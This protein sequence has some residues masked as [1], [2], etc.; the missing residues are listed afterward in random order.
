MDATWHRNVVLEGSVD[1]MYWG[2]MK[3]DMT[4]E[5]LL[6][7]NILS[8]IGGPC[9][10]VVNLDTYKVERYLYPQTGRA[11]IPRYETANPSYDTTISRGDA[12]L[13]GQINIFDLL[14]ILGNLSGKNQSIYFECDVNEDGK[15]DIFDLLALL[16]LLS[17]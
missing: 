9:L 16:K 14:V 3:V 1:N 11:A 6:L 15:I 5:K 13:D 17:N 7:S 4:G 10:A 12:N 8:Q 2:L